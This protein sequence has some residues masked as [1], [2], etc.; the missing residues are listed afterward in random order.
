[1]RPRWADRPG[2]VV[3]FRPEDVVLTGSTE[4][5]SLHR[6]AVAD[7]LALAHALNLPLPEIVFFGVQP[8][9]VGWRDEL[10]PEVAA[11]VPGL[12]AAILEE[13][14]RET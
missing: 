13:V 3:R 12:V 6:T 1:M 9:I 5:F 7:A 11:A 8:G 4:R 10:S 14:M 2:E